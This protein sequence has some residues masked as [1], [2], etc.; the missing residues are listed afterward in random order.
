[1]VETDISP[2]RPRLG[3]S[4]SHIRQTLRQI[5]ENA[6]NNPPNVNRAWEQVRITLGNATRAR[7][8]EVLKETEF[9]RR[10]RPPGKR[11]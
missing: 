11:R 9:A 2:E 10:R 4:K 8:R 5:Y 3:A 1:M 7:V 6:G